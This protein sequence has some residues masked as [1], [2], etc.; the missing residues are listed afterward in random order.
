MRERYF[1]DACQSHGKS[2]KISKLIQIIFN[3]CICVREAGEGLKKRYKYKYIYVN[4]Y[5]CALE[6]LIRVHS[7]VSLLLGI[8]LFVF[9][10]D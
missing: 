6:Q 3:A 8:R 4:N 10:F 2:F 7:K 9:F 1:T 5:N